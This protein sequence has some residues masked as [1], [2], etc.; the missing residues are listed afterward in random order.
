MNGRITP[1][2]WGI[3]LSVL[4]L[5]LIG[6]VI[7]FISFSL[8][9]A[10][11][12]TLFLIVPGA[13][14]LFQR[15]S[16]WTGLFPLALGILLL[17]SAQGVLKDGMLWQMIWAV[18]LL[19][20]GINLIVHSASRRRKVNVS[21]NYTPGNVKSDDF[22]NYTAVFGGQDKKYSKEVFHGANV[23][24]IF[25]GVKLDLR[26]AVFEGD[27]VIKATTVFGGVKIFLPQNVYVD[28]VGTNIFG[29]IS[30]HTVKPINPVA[31]L[32]LDGITVFGGIEIQ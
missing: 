14:M 30:D 12:W 31:T 22:Q 1:I 4:A 15:S 24:A 2:L 21:V 25:G 27:A 5:F 32:H 13:C 9:F 26:D 6:N 18:M 11:W 17:L 20:C 7:G 19:L 29:G 3:C 16:R 28:V 23:E 8:F 10:G